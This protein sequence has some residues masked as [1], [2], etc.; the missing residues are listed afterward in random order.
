LLPSQMCGVVISM[1]ILMTSE[2]TDMIRESLRKGTK[3]HGLFLHRRNDHLEC[4]KNDFPVYYRMHPIAF[5]D[6]F[7]DTRNGDILIGITEEQ[8]KLLIE[9]GAELE[10]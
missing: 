8:R 2:A 5:I 9:Y 3:M 1:K 6:I 10:V 4:I 7:E